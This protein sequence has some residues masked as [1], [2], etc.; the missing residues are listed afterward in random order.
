MIRK[1]LRKILL[2]SL[3]ITCVISTSLNAENSFQDMEYLI[4]KEIIK[5][6]TL[7]LDILKKRF[8]VGSEEYNSLHK[9]QQVL[10]DKLPVDSFSTYS[11]VKLH[12]IID[13][14]MQYMEKQER[15]NNKLTLDTDVNTLYLQKK[16][17]IQ[18][19]KAAEEQAKKKGRAPSNR[20]IQELVKNSPYANIYSRSKK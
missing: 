15:E 11:R 20:D 1:N 3:I 19:Q 4:N 16:L 10:L 2:S 14:N 6:T 8:D 9:A 17:M 13:K 12:N 5:E 7:R 18:K